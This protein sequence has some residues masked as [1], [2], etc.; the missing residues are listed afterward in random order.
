[1]KEYKTVDTKTVFEGE[2]IRLKVD[3]VMMPSGRV[4][5]REIVE[6]KGAVGIVPLTENGEIIMVSQYRHP[7]GGLLMEIPAGKLDP[8]ET[9]EECAA[10]ELVEEICMAPKTLIKLASFY[11]TPGYSNEVFHLFLADGLVEQHC[12]LTEEEI[13]SVEKITV[14]NAVRMIT[15]GTITDG[16]TIAAV[17]L[18]KI[19]L[20]N[21]GQ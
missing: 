16:K 18:T 5:E 4:A 12:D 13:E 1:L 10:R 11:T 3:K 17:G 15:N 19:W 14:E 9:P 2:I 7:V 21:Q 8:G 6:H 20:E